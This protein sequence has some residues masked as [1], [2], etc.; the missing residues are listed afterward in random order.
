MPVPNGHLVKELS[1]PKA[2]VNADFIINLPK[3][4]TSIISDLTLGIKNLFGCVMF[5]DRKMFHREADL[6]YYLCDIYKAVK[7]DITIVV[8]IVAMEGYGA[9]MGDPVDKVLIIGGN[10]IVAVDALCHVHG[11]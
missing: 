1:L 5:E 8:G 11:R 3:M 6:A 10:D 4:K 9:H 2:V 7:P